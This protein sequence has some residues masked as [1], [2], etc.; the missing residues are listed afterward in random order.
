M[1]TI[2]WRV[3]G[4]WNPFISTSK[5]M[6]WTSRH[7]SESIIAIFLSMI[8]LFFKFCELYL[9]LC[10]WGKILQNWWIWSSMRTVIGNWK[11]CD[12]IYFKYSIY[13]YQTMIYD[14]K[15]NWESLLLAIPVTVYCFVM[16]KLSSM[17]W[18]LILCYFVVNNLIYLLGFFFLF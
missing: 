6:W 9:I 13:F 15:N 11:Y 3:R 17:N 8:I 18:D 2:R 16:R 5:S 1:M 4:M 7:L 10:Y 12:C 14:A